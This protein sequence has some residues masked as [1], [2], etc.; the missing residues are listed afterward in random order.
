M[1]IDTL[2]NLL[3]PEVTRLGYQWWGIEYLPQ[4]KYS[5]LRIYIDKSEG[6]NLD[7]CQ[8]VSERISAVLD[9]EDPIA[10]HYSLEI[11]S[12]GI[13][14]PLF[15]REQIMAYLGQLAKVVMNIKI[16]GQRRFIGTLQAVE[17][18]RLILLTEDLGDVVLP[19]A[20]IEKTHLV[21]R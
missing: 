4:G 10:H 9:V 5:T 6:I 13:E 2:T 8:L 7:D 17:G 15:N 18:D 12:P 21:V 3:Q 1:K 16:N 20:N 11:S 14:R 19:I